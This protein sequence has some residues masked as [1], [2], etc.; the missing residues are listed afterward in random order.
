MQAQLKREIKL[1]GI[2]QK[3]QIDV[4]RPSIVFL[5]AYI[6]FLLEL[7]GILNLITLV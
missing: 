7:L 4:V 2:I 5:F 6:K 3:A 1:L